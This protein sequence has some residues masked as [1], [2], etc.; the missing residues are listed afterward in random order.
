M[1]RVDFDQDVRAGFAY[2]INQIT[3]GICELWEVDE[4]ELKKFSREELEKLPRGAEALFAMLYSLSGFLLE[5]DS[6]FAISLLAESAQGL[7]PA[8]LRHIGVQRIPVSAILNS[9]P[10]EGEWN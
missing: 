2:A 9:N 5:P 3:S 7:E 10:D 6:E 1:D 8:V 4:N